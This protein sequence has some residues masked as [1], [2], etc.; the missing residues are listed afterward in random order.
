[1]KFIK[2]TRDFYIS[3]EQIIAI[4]VYEETAANLSYSRYYAVKV[5]PAR[6][7]DRHVTLKTFDRLD[8][9]EKFLEEVAAKFNEEELK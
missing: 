2:V 8:D 5:V 3:R 6:F 9:A 7:N 4:G 1:M